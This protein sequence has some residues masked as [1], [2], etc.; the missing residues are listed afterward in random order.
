LSN[1]IAQCSIQPFDLTSLPSIIA[2]GITLATKSGFARGQGQLVG[3][4]VES[5][6]NLL[7][8]I[9]AELLWILQKVASFI[10]SQSLLSSF[11]RCIFL[12]IRLGWILSNVVVCFAFILSTT[13]DGFILNWSSCADAGKDSSAGGN[14]SISMTY[15]IRWH[16]HIYNMQCLLPP[17][18]C[19]GASKNLISHTDHGVLF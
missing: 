12:S 17:V 8:G 2:C 4:I 18:V 1:T 9:G 14:P 19:N 11:R 13:T 10:D 16:I 7:R 6:K 15:N 3:G 5:I